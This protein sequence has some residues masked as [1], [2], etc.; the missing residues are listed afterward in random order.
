MKR[1][2]AARLFFYIFGISL[3]IGPVVAR[4]Q[5][6]DDGKQPLPKLPKSAIYYAEPKH[7]PGQPPPSTTVPSQNGSP[8][9]SPETHAHR[10]PAA[11]PP[12]SEA[13]NQ[14]EGRGE[15][16]QISP[17]NQGGSPP[18]A[19]EQVLNRKLGPEKVQQ[20][21]GQI[22]GGVSSADHWFDGAGFRAGNDSN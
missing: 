8:A 16:V 14:T 13:A 12:V 21:L 9:S 6:Q 22:Q 18:P 5:Q 7:K 1:H 4:S 10:Q 11:R 3:I 2:I 17:V 20:L 15:N 19:T